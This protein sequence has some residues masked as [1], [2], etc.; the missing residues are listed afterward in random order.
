MFEL[1]VHHHAVAAGVYD[2]AAT[3]LATADKNGD[4][5]IDYCEFCAMM[6]N[7]NEGLRT[8]RSEWWGLAG[9]G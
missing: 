9:F 1:A 3:L 8:S 4:G 6:R 5:S 7:Q 2:D